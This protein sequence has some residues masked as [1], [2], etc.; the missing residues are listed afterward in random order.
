MEALEA[1]EVWTGQPV[2]EGAFTPALSLERE[3]Y[4]AGG[5]YLLPREG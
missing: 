5:G 4:N 1:P 2:R 3:G